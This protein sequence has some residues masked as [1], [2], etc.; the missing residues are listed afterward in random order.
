[1]HRIFCAA[2]TAL[3]EER[4]AFHDEIGAFNEQAMSHNILFVPASMV[5]NMANMTLFEKVLD[6][7]IQAC[8]YYV[9]VLAESWK[10][11]R[12]DHKRLLDVAL[13]C[14]ADPQMPMQEVVLMS[15]AG[16]VADGARV[17][18]FRDLD[19]F[20]LEVRTLFSEWIES[21]KGQA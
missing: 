8:R 3:E 17:V 12:G 5:L 1:M 11:E 16:L 14:V 19:T 2:P 4:L 6:D 20:R 10:E 18:E 9:Q 13:Q 15:K 21:L 7:N